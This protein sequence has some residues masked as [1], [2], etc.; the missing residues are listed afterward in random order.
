MS[1]YFAVSQDTLDQITELYD[2]IWPTVSAM[3]NL[4][5]QIKGFVNEV[6]EVNDSDLVKRFDWGSKI[7]GV[8]LKRAY[9]E[10]SWEVQQERF[11]KV[12]L[13]NLI[14]IYEGWIADLQS[15]LNFNPGLSKDLQ[16][17]TQTD[18]Q[19]IPTH[20]I[21]YAIQQIC[22]PPSTLLR[23]AFYAQLV[24]QRKYSLARLDSLLKCYRFFKESRNCL[25]HHGGKAS[26]RL[27]DA[28][29]TFQAVAAPADLGMVEV[30]RHHP[31]ALGAP[32]QLDLRGV[33]GLSDIIIRIIV[34][35]DAELS[36]AQSAE[37]ELIRRGREWAAAHPGELDFP[38][39]QVLRE[40]RLRSLLRSCAFPAAGEVNNIFLLLCR[41]GIIR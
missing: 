35:L 33:V 16:F 37:E 15:T 36:G 2:F 3:W 23:D 41:E 18:P 5:W 6:G 32:V 29:Q 30:P 7:H 38:Q 17:P 34:T 10:Q 9:L 24:T 27:V 11:A 12:L 25:A 22:T 28:Y 1:T 40:N 26:P 19:N 31:V 20:G 21:R 8:N 14:S 39:D 13:V 4:R